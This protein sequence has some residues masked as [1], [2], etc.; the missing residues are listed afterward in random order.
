MKS[1]GWLLERGQDGGRAGAGQE[2]DRSRTG[3]RQ[4]AGQGQGGGR[5]GAGLGVFLENGRVRT[6]PDLLQDKQVSEG[7]S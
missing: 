1:L 5:A 7:A 3:A 6:L 2:Q 4:G